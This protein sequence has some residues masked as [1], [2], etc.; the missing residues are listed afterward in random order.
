MTFG[1]NK[2]ARYLSA[3]IMVVAVLLLIQI[4]V[5]LVSVHGSKFC[6]ARIS[7]FCVAADS[8]WSIQSIA[9]LGGAPHQLSYVIDMREHSKGA[10]QPVFVSSLRDGVPRAGYRAVTYQ[11]RVF[12]GKLNPANSI[13]G[14][15][16]RGPSGRDLPD[17]VPCDNYFGLGMVCSNNL[18]KCYVF[19]NPRTC[20]IGY[21]PTWA[22]YY[23]Y[24]SIL[25]ISGN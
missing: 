4:L 2:L 14:I 8:S 17:I 11:E 7:N 24:S 9:A 15:E 22:V 19:D 3:S 13:I 6:Y 18:P 16:V 12:V 23:I 20:H 1:G 25:T 21:T 10:R 5:S